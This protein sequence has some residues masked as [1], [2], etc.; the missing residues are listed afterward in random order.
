M[1][2]VYIIFR[3]IEVADDGHMR[4]M[5][6]GKAVTGIGNVPKWDPPRR[7]HKLL[8]DKEKDLEVVVDAGDNEEEEQHEN[9]EISSDTHL[10]ASAPPK[11]SDE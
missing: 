9:G 1:N 7:R 4:L 10:E 2:V 5:C 3:F 11:Y 8:P 6:C